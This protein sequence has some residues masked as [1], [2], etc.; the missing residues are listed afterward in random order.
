MDKW[1]NISAE[2]ANT[3]V[4]FVKKRIVAAEEWRLQYIKSC[5]VQGLRTARHAWAGGGGGPTSPRCSVPSCQDMVVGCVPVCLCAC[6]PVCLCACVP[7]VHVVCRGA[8]KY[9]ANFVPVQRPDD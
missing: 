6:V 2:E 9:N 8:S 7:V 3:D 4:N 1:R 5:V